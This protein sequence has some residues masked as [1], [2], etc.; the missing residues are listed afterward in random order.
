MF[1][2][3]IVISW[4]IFI[5]SSIR[6]R[7]VQQVC[8]CDIKLFIAFSVITHIF[9]IVLIIIVHNIHVCVYA[10]NFMPKKTPKVKPWKF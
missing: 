5:I 1:V 2:G 4:R 3:F 10:A 6:V 7:K 8:R 9:P